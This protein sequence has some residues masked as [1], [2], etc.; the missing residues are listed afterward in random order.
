MSL[1][2]RLAVGCRVPNRFQGGSDD[3]AW[4]A[5][6]LG[7]AAGEQAAAEELDRLRVWHEQVTRLARAVDA[8]TVGELLAEVEAEQM[9]SDI[10]EWLQER[11]EE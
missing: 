11:T 9:I 3:D 8:G 4:L 10:E 5:Y 2:S 1:V 7:K 6:Q